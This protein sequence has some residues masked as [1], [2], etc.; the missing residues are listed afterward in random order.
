M[1]GR[2]TVSDFF[3]SEIQILQRETLNMV[4]QTYSSTQNES[5]PKFEIPPR[6]WLQ[7]PFEVVILPTFLSTMGS[8]HSSSL[9]LSRDS[10]L[11]RGKK[12]LFGTSERFTVCFIVIL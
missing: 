1:T 9:G 12:G 6:F 7:A 2:L 4:F 8:R 11:R 3:S 5:G 10:P